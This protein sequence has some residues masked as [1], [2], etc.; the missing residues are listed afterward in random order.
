MFKQSVFNTIT[1]KYYMNYEHTLNEFRYRVDKNGGCQSWVLFLKNDFDF[2][3]KRLTFWTFFPPLLYNFLEV[4][5]NFFS[6][7]LNREEASNEL[8]VESVLWFTRSAIIWKPVFF[9]VFVPAIT[10]GNSFVDWP[11]ISRKLLPGGISSHSN[12]A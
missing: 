5:L 12:I 11:V 2:F 8:Q 7:D 10:N 9:E 1:M 3:W 4:S 6:H